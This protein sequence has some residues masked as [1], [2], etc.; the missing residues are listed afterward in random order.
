V[1][2]FKTISEAV[3]ALLIETVTILS[4]IKTEYIII[5]GWSP[6]LLGDKSLNHPGTKDIDILFSDGYQEGEIRSVIKLFLDK[7]FCVSAKHDFQLLK[8]VRVE[9]YDL[10]FNVDLLHP[11]ETINNPELLVDHFD[12]GIRNTD[13]PG[14]KFVRSIV[15]PSSELFFLDGFTSEYEFT[16][17][18]LDGKPSTINFP[19]LNLS[20]LV[21]SKCE[22]VSQ[23][24][25]PRDAFDIFTAMYS[26]KN[27]V[28]DHQLSQYSNIEAVN[29]LLIE[30]V[31][32]TSNDPEEL[33]EHNRFDINV[34]KYLDKEFNSIK[35]MDV[36]PSELVKSRIEK[37]IKNEHIK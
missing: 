27:G 25:R 9:N 1:H 31:K 16:G 32:F 4:S 5:G 36:L 17:I 29:N 6:Y 10:I 21:L 23:K 33:S 7:G 18:S 11:S 15:L 20:G 2:T 13:V 30:L 12:L 22:S 24:K 37:I 26:D 3:N 35:E 19:L 28:I 14:N 34:N 8:A